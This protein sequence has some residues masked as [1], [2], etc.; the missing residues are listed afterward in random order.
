VLPESIR[1]TLDA[2]DELDRYINEATGTVTVIRSN[3]PSEQGTQK[4]TLYQT[5]PGRYE[6]EIPLAETGQSVYHL[7]TELRLGDR[8]LENQSRSIMTRYSDELRIRPTN[9]ALLRQ[10][11]ELTGGSYDI[12]AEEIAH[13]QSGRSARQALPLWTWLLSIAAGLFVLDV[14]LRRV[15]ILVRVPRLALLLGF[16]LRG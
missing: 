14:L 9:E 11:A 7:Q 5:A 6:A 3:L 10:L 4:W 12:A 8:V 1:V 15:E 2:M 16:V 13:W